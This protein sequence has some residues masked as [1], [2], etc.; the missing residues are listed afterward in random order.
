MNIPKPVF[1]IL[2]PRFL[3]DINHKLLLGN[4]RIWGLKLHYVF[5]YS[6]IANLSIFFLVLV[7]PINYYHY[8]NFLWGGTI[9]ISILEAIF[10]VYWFKLQLIYNIEKQY[11]HFRKRNTLIE[12]FGYGACI[13][14]IIS[15]TLV[16]FS[17]LELKL[18]VNK[19]RLIVNTIILD[20]IDMSGVEDFD[21]VNNRYHDRSYVSRLA[22]ENE[23]KIKGS[24][25]IHRNYKN[26]FRDIKNFL[27]KGDFAKYVSKDSLNYT[28]ALITDTGTDTDSERNYCLMDKGKIDKRKIDLLQRSM[29]KE[30]LIFY[31]INRNDSACQLLDM[32]LNSQSEKKLLNEKSLSNILD[33]IKDGTIDEFLAI[34]KESTGTNIKNIVSQDMK[35]NNMDSELEK[36]KAELEL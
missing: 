10:L 15:G 32:L 20:A 24:A 6:L 19:E 17:S 35:F 21:L 4:P 33:S 7:T 9:I 5:Y 16:F 34:I 2:F 25:V 30:S 8:P 14:L 22:I 12:V 1:R 29:G 31:L 23:K 13:L 18:L 11:G 36:R 27:I 26:Y 3:Q 28:D